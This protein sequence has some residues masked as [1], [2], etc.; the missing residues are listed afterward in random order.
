VFAIATFG[1]AWTIVWC[2]LPRKE[3]SGRLRQLFIGDD[4]RAST[5]KTQYMLWTLFI[6]FALAYVAG[7]VLLLGGDF[8]C[9]VDSS[10]A[11]EP[12]DWQCVGPGWE[13]YLILLGV[14]AAAAVAAKGITTYKVVNGIVQKTESESTNPIQLA[15]DDLGNPDII[16]VQYLLFNVITLVYAS[17]AFGR[18][19]ILGDVPDILLGLTSA[20]AATYVLNKSLQSSKPT[21]TAVLPSTI[22]AGTRVE[23]RGQ[24]L[25][26]SS[27]DGEPTVKLGGIV[28]EELKADRS[29]NK[30]T[31]KA[32]F[33]MTTDSPS[34]IVITAAH[35]ETA[36]YPIQVQ[37]FRILGP[38]PEAAGQQVIVLGGGPPAWSKAQVNYGA[39][40]VAGTMDGTPERVKVSVPV[41]A[42]KPYDLVVHIDGRSTAPYRVT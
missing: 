21:I 40:I 28:A 19:Q 32:P 13:K 24:N 33:G 5:S 22:A 26:P 29:Q 11:D 31:V 12:T 7:A 36:G 39:T 37:D 35:V 20:A 2:V 17:V 23:I 30:V 10:K 25:F 34:A 16:D 18:T 4:L 6:T 9:A 14:P 38:E 15:T 8:M 42:T 27:V 3:N 41:A 1:F